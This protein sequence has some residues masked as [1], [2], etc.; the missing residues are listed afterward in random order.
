PG[1]ALAV[2]AA[3]PGGDPV[4]AA[5]ATG[6]LPS[7]EMVAAL[8]DQTRMPQGLAVACLVATLI[9]LLAATFLADRTRLFTLSGPI[10]PPQV[11]EERAKEVV[12]ELGTWRPSRDHVWGFTFDRSLVR[13]VREADTSATRWDSLAVA[14]QPLEFWYR[15]S[16]RPLVAHNQ[17]GQVYLDDPPNVVPGMVSVTL[18]P[19]G[20]LRSWSSVPPANVEADSSAHA[21]DW[22]RIFRLAGLDIARFEEAETQ[23]IPP[24]YAD[25]RRAWTG[26]YPGRDIP[27]RVEAATL[28]GRLVHFRSIAP[29]QQQSRAEGGSSGG[30]GQVVATSLFLSVL[31]GSILVAYRNL[32]AG[33]GDRKGAT[34][35]AVLIVALLGLR[36][37]AGAHHVPS[38]QTEWNLIV[39]SLGLGLFI[40]A[41]TFVMYSALEPYARRHWPELLISWSRALHGR[42]RDARV[43]RDLLV[44]MTAGACFALLTPLILV[45]SRE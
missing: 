21:V 8:G 13:W 2:A 36:L 1:S 22:A 38:L 25:S 7:P 42:I 3:L 45:V 11:L 24:V 31:V 15:Q 33:R 34:R 41:L 27:L 20:L 39:F 10:K 9:A 12:N 43:G 29:W 18:S 17:V 6:E 35:L 44:G 32:K 28:Q 40:G 37:L 23:W 5:L 14:P 19:Q 26:T 30:F 4:A 16:P